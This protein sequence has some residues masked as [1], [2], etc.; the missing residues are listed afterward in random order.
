[1]TWQRRLPAL[2]RRA[3][4][5]VDA[6]RP[7]RRPVVRAVGK[8]AL[9]GVAALVLLAF[10]AVRI[11]QQVG[12]SEAVRDAKVETRLAGVGI[13]A[14]ALSGGLLDGTPAAV[15]RFDRLVRRRVLRDPVVRVK[16]W[17]GRGRILY[18]DE[19]RLIGARYTLGP[20]EL[21]VLRTGGV[22]A[23]VSDL[24]KPE[25]RFDRSYGKLLE[26]Y[27]GIRGPHGTPL[28]YE[29]YLRYGSVAASANR[30]WSR[31]APALLVSLIALELLQIPPAWSLARRVRR[32]Q[33]EREALLR[34]AIEASELERRR[35]A[36]NLHDG[37]VQTLA[38]VSYSLSAA[39]EHVDGRGSP[40]AAT[41][42]DRAAA[43]TR[44]SI[45]ELR[46]LL[47]EIYPPALRR[48]GLKAALSDLLAPLE[49][50]DVSTRLEVPPDLELPT[51]A[52]SVLYRVAQEALRNVAKHARAQHVRVVAACDGG[53]AVLRVE[54]DGIG[55][56]A[57]AL[58]GSA[59]PGHFGLQIMQDLARDAG[60]RLTVDSAPGA[61]TR[62]RLE[63]PA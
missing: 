57:S 20:D 54:D 29:D 49:A 31:F 17:D 55:F 27:L 42:I 39:S 63:V 60:G 2:R 14:P 10:V 50:R 12:R 8:F 13:V 24:A 4:P 32:G 62:I 3:R 58:D 59:R 18:S 51:D 56:A 34:R 25:N 28:L 45:R 15:A 61:G 44:Q 52:E 5:P 53:R 1:V 36:G 43:D 33:L 41:M 6:A 11:L 37:V 48:A 47:V 30:L 23:E 21:H 38:G 46:T 35:I 26:V 7:S 9:T 22:D 40:R 19:H 16:I